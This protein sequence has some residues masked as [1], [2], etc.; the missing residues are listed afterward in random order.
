[1][2]E[3]FKI[4]RNWIIIFLFYSAIAFLFILPVFYGRS[5]IYGGDMLY[6]LRRI[7]ELSMNIKHGNWYP[8]LYAYDFKN[9]L[10]PGGI[11]YPQITLLPF[12]ILKAIFNGYFIPVVFGWYFYTIITLINSHMVVYRYSRNFSQA[13]FASI[14]YCFSTYR[15][16]DV[17]HRF[18]LGEA[19]SMCFLPLVIYGI[20]SIVFGNCKEWPFLS[21]GLGF[22]VFSHVLS[23]YLDVAFCLVILLL[24]LKSVLKN[25]LKFRI[26]ALLKSIL[27]F[28]SISAIYL[29]PFITQ[30][31]SQ[32]FTSA[33]LLNLSASAPSLSTYLLSSIDN[34]LLQTS[35]SVYNPGII[36]IFILI[37]GIL[38]FK[39]IDIMDRGILIISGV[40]ILGVTS[41]FPWFIFNGVTPVSII[42]F[43]FRLL[44]F[45]TFLLAVLG[46]K[47]M[48]MLTIRKGLMFKSVVVLLLMTPYV[49]SM[50]QYS[51]VIGRYSDTTL[52][53][54]L[55][56]GEY[57]SYYTDQYIPQKGFS[58]YNDV[59]KHKGTIN[60][61]H[62]TLNEFDKSP[63]KIVFENVVLNKGSKVIIPIYFLKNMS[64]SVSNVKQKI[65][66]TS[67]GLIQFTSSSKGKT[68]SV[69]YD[70]SVYD[71]LG[72][73]MSIVTIGIVTVVVLYRSIR[74]KLGKA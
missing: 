19:I 8:Y 29:I 6:H 33:P 13:A 30:M 35:T 36:S 68:I 18:A 46:G 66:E 4:K 51:S 17:W 61:D 21:I 12:S 62:V 5:L 48:S 52:V 71:Q 11:F 74:T 42:Q 59:I 53:Q 60:G 58:S 49:S 14:I 10:F 43:S 31:V 1:M 32:T 41:I 69:Y 70:P 7:N 55:E 22:T 50:H 20:Y 63:N 24:G 64:V 26:L 16:I 34:T 25:Y 37:A 72:M 47:L 73:V 15:A 9:F 39:K 23:T 57:I 27:L 45:P 40:I 38:M 3:R 67:N 54:L 56:K 65:R 28:A 2:V 44:I